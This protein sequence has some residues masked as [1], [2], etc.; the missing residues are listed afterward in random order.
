MKNKVDSTTWNDYLIGAL[1]AFKLKDLD[2]A[3]H[4]LDKAFIESGEDVPYLYLLAGHIA[5]ARGA[6]KE[7]E[8]A[9][10]KVLEL[11]PENA[12]AWNNLGVLY[13]KY[14]DKEKAL[15][16]FQEAENKAPDRPDI[17][18]NIGNL[19]K[20]NGD[21]DKAV[22]Y[23]NR[24]IQVDPDYAPAFNNLGTLYE[25][26]KERDKALEVFRRGLSADS[27][28][29]SL[30]F[31]M[32]LVYQEEE[33]WDDARE[34]FD[35]ALK[36]RPGWVP[37]LNNLG[38]VLQEMGKEDE[39]ARTFRTLLNIEPENINALNN[40]GVAYDHLGRTDDA[41]NCYKKALRE[42]PGYVKAALNLHS[43]YHENQELNEALEEVN[44]QIT[45]HPQVPEIRVRMAQTLIGLSRWE[46]AE[47]S[48]DHVIERNPGHQDALRTKAD[49]FLAT[50]RPEEAEKIL[51]KLPHEPNA[52]RD[53]AKLNIST[54]RP[55][56]AERLLG[57]LIAVNPDDAESRR[58]MSDLLAEKNP[59]EAL[60][61]RKEAVSTAP[62]NTGDMISMAELYSKTG[63]KDLAMGKLNEAV[64]LLGSR[65]SGD[66]LDEME[67]VLTLYENAAKTL[68]SENAD[69]FS[70]RTAQLSRKLKSA[71]GLSDINPRNKG[72]F[73]FEEIPLDEEDALS[74]LDLNAMEPVIRI[75][76]EE[77]T[78]FLEESTED[79]EEA[80]T[81][82]YR[83]EN[84]KDEPG[85]SREPEIA[86]LTPSG[87]AT[88][89]TS[90][91]F[92]PEPSPNGPPVH[93]HL[94]QQSS[95]PQPPQ[96]IY[97][98]IHPVSQAVPPQ[99]Q[100]MPDVSIEEISDEDIPTFPEEEPEE[101]SMEQILEEEAIEEP[102]DTILEITEEEEPFFEE[103]EDGSFFIPESDALSED[104]PE[105][106]EPE[107]PD[108]DL[109]FSE[110]DQPEEP[111]LLEEL[112]DNL[113]LIEDFETE[114]ENPIEKVE[115]S[116]SS[117]KMAE[118]FKYLSNLT[119]ET[120]GE[121]RQQLI[122]EEVPL[123]L[124]GIHAKLTGEPNFREI[125]QKYDRRHRERHQVELNE[126]TIRESLNAFKE[127]AESY[128][129][130]S[131]GESLS[132]KLGKIMSYVSR[133][134]ET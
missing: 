98:D 116:L 75:N 112:D 2:L 122:D 117:D 55:E 123:K 73:S 103:E 51:K 10:K 69:L 76:E 65:N 118:M 22:T 26:K 129:T 105:S 20:S 70:E 60:R 80:Y 82:L 111:V 52:I 74:L 42:E 9:W 95:V 56:N 72:Q 4:R 132:K 28:D 110:K 11:E 27:G 36:K 29:A 50:R 90:P 124:A 34:A 104:L 91:N 5:H 126:E 120:V 43:S 3:E 47:Q 31:N 99:P 94:P 19:Y 93:I 23:Y 35:T 101:N 21:L 134:K 87:S 8:K 38:I 68:E 17:P 15:A 12:E 121:G 24:A 119:D 107:I 40:L 49:L 109:V 62:G 32:G 7:A 89:T 106:N 66:A 97:Q 61:L 37:G 131:V 130:Q 67:S 83:P 64:T 6:V 92:K 14:G 113:T 84:I 86:G 54:E 25:S 59:E 44:K 33:R 1:R 71:I 57:E 39:A 13:R 18:Y 30:R 115:E 85:F 133:K 81:E 100:E 78:V 127:L 79:L 125:A 88:D 96:V 53:L 114:E 45:L 41:R 108:A 128:P 63:K 102:E 58:L 16:A 46:E 77:E 48:L